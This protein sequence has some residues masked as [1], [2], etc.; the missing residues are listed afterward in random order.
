MKI[1]TYSIH[2]RTGTFITRLLQSGL[3]PPKLLEHK[4]KHEL[5]ANEIVLL[6]YYIA[7]VNIENVYHD[8]CDEAEGEYTPFDALLPIHSIQNPRQRSQK[9]FH[10]TQNEWRI[11]KSTASSLS[12]I[13]HTQ[14]G[15]DRQMIMP[16]TK[17]MK[18]WIDV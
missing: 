10:K 3:I 2:Y 16:K 11:S 13:H 14:S 5:H 12:A 4:Y 15:R 1:Y 17:H 18:S 9:C 7:S 8:I 6:A